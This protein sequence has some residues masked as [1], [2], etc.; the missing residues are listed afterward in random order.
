M[1]HT[2]RNS[3]F[4]VKI[5]AQGAELLS[6]CRLTDSTEFIWQGDAKIW[7][8]HA[9]VLFPI[10]GR[11]PEHKYLLNGK[12]Y[13]LPQHGFARDLIFE[14]KE[15]SEDRITFELSAT[16]FTK[17]HYPFNFRLVITYALT[18]NKLEVTYQVYNQD[19]QTMPF[20]IG[21]HPG[22][23]CPLTPGF[24]FEDYFLEFEE[25]QTLERHLLQDGLLNGKTETILENSPKLPLNR[26][27]FRKDAIVLKQSPIQKITLKT[28]SDSRQVE[29][30]FSDYPYLGI[31]TQPQP[32]ATF[33]C[34]EP[35]QGIASPAGPPT[36]LA[37]KE[38]IINLPA[39]QQFECSY[40]IAVN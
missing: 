20:S 39:G 31:W 38:G 30:Q 24:S 2:L 6:F 22:F 34:L 18:S 19:S 40:S 36:E 12:P 4:E 16:E 8:R 17:A 25:P 5:K 35:W 32:E 9:P 14:P 3:E 27:L 26:D 7:P 1:V 37:Q 21:A 11:L 23:N 15:A 29:M 13:H 10:V 33:L 28:A